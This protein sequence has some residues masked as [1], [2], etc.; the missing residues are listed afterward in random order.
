[1]R[2]PNCKDPMNDLRG[3]AI[4]WTLGLALCAIVITV[5][6]FSPIFHWKP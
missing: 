5:L 4:R 2:Y 6:I 1:M 3:D